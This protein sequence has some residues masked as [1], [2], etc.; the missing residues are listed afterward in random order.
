[1]L[2]RGPLQRQRVV[3]DALGG[4]T[5]IEQDSKGLFEVALPPRLRHVA[6]SRLWSRWQRAPQRL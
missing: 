1:M 3:T 4:L 6:A 5:A 2:V